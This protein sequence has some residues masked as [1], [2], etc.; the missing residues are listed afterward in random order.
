MGRTSVNKTVNV[1]RGTSMANP[2]TQIPQTA[3]VGGRAI[4]NRSA[5]LN[6]GLAVRPDTPLAATPEPKLIV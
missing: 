5:P 1:A 3:T 2:T 6:V 4:V